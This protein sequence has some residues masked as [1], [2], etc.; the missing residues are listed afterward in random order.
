[1]TH[2]LLPALGA[3]LAASPFIAT[4]YSKLNADTDPEPGGSDD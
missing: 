3:T 2:S 1:M 4:V